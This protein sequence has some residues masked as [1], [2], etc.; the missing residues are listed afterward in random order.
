MEEVKQKRP[1]SKRVYRDEAEI[2]AICVLRDCGK[3]SWLAITRFLGLKESSKR[4][5][6]YIYKQNHEK[7]SCQRGQSI[8]HIEDENIIK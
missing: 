8:V 4:N 2:K 5:C 3:M 1:Y 6:E 7:Y